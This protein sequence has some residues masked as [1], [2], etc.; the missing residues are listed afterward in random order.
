M[1]RVSL[2]TSMLAACSIFRLPNA[3]T[4]NCL[5]NSRFSWKKHDM[6]KRITMICRNHLNTDS[7]FCAFLVWIPKMPSTTMMKSF[8]FCCDDLAN[9][10][11]EN[12]SATF[13]VGLTLGHWGIFFG[14]CLKTGKTQLIHVRLNRGSPFIETNQLSHE[15]TLVG[16]VI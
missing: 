9:K 12:H 10:W 4:T 8:V 5:Q 3:Q 13:L 16:W 15:K 2:P 14:S 6:P 7:F 11:Q 1:S